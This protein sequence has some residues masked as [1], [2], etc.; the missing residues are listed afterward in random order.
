MQPGPFPGVVF[1]R[2]GGLA[3]GSF[4]VPCQGVKKWFSEAYWLVGGFSSWLIC[5]GTSNRQRFSGT[6]RGAFGLFEF[7]S[8]FK[9]FIFVRTTPLDDASGENICCAKR[10]ALTSSWLKRGRWLWGRTHHAVVSGACSIGAGRRGRND[11]ATDA[12]RRYGVFMLI[13][14]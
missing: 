13:E 1:H 4:Y 3:S 2:L 7:S 6:G 5:N 10:I 9:L 14:K 12:Q 11:S 8:N